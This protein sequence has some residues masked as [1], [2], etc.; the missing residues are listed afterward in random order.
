MIQK[1]TQLW[2]TTLLFLFSIT[3]YTGIATAHGNVS[4]EA[5]NCMRS[6]SG[7]MVH[8]S[9]YQPQFDPE[10]EYCTEI[11][12]EGETMWALD[13]VDHALREM[14]IVIKIVKGSGEAISETVASWRSVN[15]HDGI[16]KGE[17]NLDQGQ[18]TV[19]ITGEGIPSLHYEYP[20][21][22]QMTNYVDTF[23]TAALTMLVLL[24]LALLTNKYL[25]RRRAQH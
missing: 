18:Y 11:P 9:T 1:T 20:L 15:H 2:A 10:A 16:I 8:L 19:F 7:S 12:K 17:F 6:M 3:L 13:L 4:L 23:R 14:P 22:V 21:R 25:E 5:D 24:L